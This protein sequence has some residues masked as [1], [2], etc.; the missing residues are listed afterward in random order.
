ML[1]FWYI[2]Y[3][4]PSCLKFRVL[5]SYLFSIKVL[6]IYN[7]L[8]FFV[9]NFIDICVLIVERIYCQA[10]QVA[11]NLPASVRHEGLTPCLGRSPK[12][13][14]SNPLQYSCLANPMDRGS[15]GARV[16]KRVRHNLET[17][18]I[19][20]SLIRRVTTVKVSS[21]FILI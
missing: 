15:W 7:A 17:E 18:H 13:G 5:V 9:F 19:S 11:Q 12:L 20:C 16:R 8:S 21:N 4:F 6:L 10:S 14:N 2:Q 3:S 1:F